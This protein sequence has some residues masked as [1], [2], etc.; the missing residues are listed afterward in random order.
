[1]KKLLIIPFIFLGVTCF[2][3]TYQEELSKVFDKLSKNENC[4]IV[5]TVTVYTN[6][7]EK[8]KTLTLSASMEKSGKQF[9]TVVQGEEVIKGED[10]IIVIDHEEELVTLEK[11]DKLKR[12]D[13][14]FLAEF[15]SLDVEE[16]WLSEPQLI[17]VN[18]NIK[19]FGLSYKYGE[20]L[21]CEV[22]INTSSHVVQK[23][24]Y[25][26]DPKLYPTNNYI[27]VLYSTFDFNPNFSKNYFA[28]EDIIQKKSGKYELV[29]KYQKYELQNNLD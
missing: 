8:T 20:I 14:K 23:V 11:I 3:Q 7:K 12:K 29:G 18:G 4:K 27:E 2:G 25:F 1:M 15:Y 26:Y 9:R 13:E 6:S 17:H 28:G 22:S 19:T 10:F 21:N 16:N 24:A 5:S